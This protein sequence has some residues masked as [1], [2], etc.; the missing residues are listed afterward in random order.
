MSTTAN[1]LECIQHKFVAVCFNNF[2]PHVHY[3]Y[4]Y[5]LEHLKLHTLHKR[6]YHLDALFLIQVYLGS[7][8]CPLSETVLLGMSWD[9]PVLAMPA[10][11]VT[12]VLLLDAPQPIM[13]FVGTSMYFEPKLFLLIIFY[14]GTFS[15][16]IH[17]EWMYVCMNVCI[18]FSPHMLV[19]LHK[20]NYYCLNDISCLVLSFFSF[21][22]LV[23]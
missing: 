6:R 12:I 4:A 11:Q 19:W 20:L 16:I 5:G 9:F 10:L 2:F 7:I 21:V 1:K 14:N 17:D 8:F 23:S 22:C 18:F 15:I 13:L 3:S